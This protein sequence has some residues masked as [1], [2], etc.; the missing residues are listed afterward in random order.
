[1]ILTTERL[2]L[3]EFIENDWH[4]IFAYQADPRYLQYSPWTYRLREQVARL[5]QECIR[6]QSEQP[7][8]KFQLAIVLRTNHLLIGTCGIRMATAHVQEAEL[9]YELHPEYWGQGYATEAARGML[10]FG[11]QTLH[12]QR[13]WAECVAE[14]IASARVLARLGMRYTQR[15]HQHTV[16]QNR[17][18][19]VLVYAIDRAEWQEQTEPRG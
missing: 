17:W 5:V 15:L 19:D 2:L 8:S 3:R 10:A 9:G 14:N 4:A 11:F 12:L 6:W 16:M 13:V 7:R 1:M 18:W